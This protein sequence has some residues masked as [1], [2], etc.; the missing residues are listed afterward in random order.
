MVH[1]DCAT[2]L[3]IISTDPYHPED[4]CKLKRNGNVQTIAK[5]YEGGCILPLLQYKNTRKSYIVICRRRSENNY[6]CPVWQNTE[7]ELK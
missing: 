4:F 7:A 2:E 1:G 6:V 3:K 5:Q